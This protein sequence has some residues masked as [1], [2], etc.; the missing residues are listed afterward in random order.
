M[1]VPLT[2]KLAALSLLLVSACSD[3]LLPRGQLMI[4]ISSDMSV[5]KDMDEVRVEVKRADGTRLPDREIP[6]LP[7]QP[8]PFGKPLPG[9]LAIVPSDAGG[10]AVRVRLTARRFNEKTGVSESRVVREAIVKVP[11]DRVAMLRMPLR[12]L[13]DAK[14]EPTDADSFR[15][16]CPNEDDT[17]VA[18][19]CKPAK[20]EQNLLPDYLPSQVFGGG[21]STGKG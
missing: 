15:S 12:W 8:A 20:I 5:V 4:A 2:S 7:S 17:C 18:G 13:C 21:T 1:D 11:T 3:E 14:I 16:A 19:A 6:I 10:Q 9:T